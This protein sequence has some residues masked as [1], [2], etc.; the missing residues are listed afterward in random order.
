[1]EIIAYLHNN[2]LGIPTFDIGKWLKEVDSNIQIHLITSCAEQH[3]D[4]SL[5][6]SI[7]WVENCRSDIDAISERL[8]HRHNIELLVSHYETDME[9][10]SQ[11]REKHGIPGQSFA[12]AS[13]YRNKSVMKSLC[14]KKGLRV[15]KFKQYSSISQHAQEIEETF[16]FPLVTKPI[17]GV[18][19]DA[20]HIIHHREQLE[21]LGAE[22]RACLVE[23]YIQGD[24]FHVDGVV[25]DGAVVFSTCHKYYGT[26]LNFQNGDEIGTYL[27]NP[28]LALAQQLRGFA[29][30]VV[31]AL[32]QT[33]DFVF[34]CELF[35]KNDGEVVFCE[36]ASRPPGGLIAMGIEQAYGVRLNEIHIKQQVGVKYPKTFFP[37]RPNQYSASVTYSPKNGKLKLLE[38]VLPDDKGVVLS[39]EN[40]VEGKEYQVG[41]S[42]AEYLLGAVLVGASF[43]DMMARYQALSDWFYG[44]FLFVEQR[45]GQTA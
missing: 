27:I 25:T 12:S 29:H 22:E 2:F 26:P 20:T 18:G 44:N 42:V 1:M 15:P 13:A 4:H 36:I 34:H 3:I 6:E 19:A 35:V 41:E 30:D 8:I 32:P 9:R 21:H 43:E 28:E 39:F 7:H 11:L 17:S 33:S 40:Y 10:V 5:F 14:Q 23:E 31:G 45:D 37:T 24:M 38:P 16:G